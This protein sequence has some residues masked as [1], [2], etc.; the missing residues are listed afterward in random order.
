MYAWNITEVVKCNRTKLTG[1]TKHGELSPV[2][3]PRHKLRLVWLRSE[4]VT[5]LGRLVS[6]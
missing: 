4:Y 2:N 1:V 5:K 6:V 3:K